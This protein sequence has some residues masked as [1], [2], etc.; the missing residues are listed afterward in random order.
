MLSTRTDSR[1]AACAD[2]RWHPIRLEVA[3]MRTVRILILAAVAMTVLTGCRGGAT[4]GPAASG[5]TPPDQIID[6]TTLRT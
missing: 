3:T 5:P 6:R 1:G 4:A 2:A